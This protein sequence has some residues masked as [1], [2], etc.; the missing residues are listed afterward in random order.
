MRKWA[1]VLAEWPFFTGSDAHKKLL[2]LSY[3]LPI[4][5][6]TRYDNFMEINPLQLIHIA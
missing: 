1:L 4:W 2:F 3:T 5:C 6:R